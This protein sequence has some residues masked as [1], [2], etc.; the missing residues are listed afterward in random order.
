M[1]RLKKEMNLKIV[2]YILLF[3]SRSKHY[4]EQKLCQNYLVS[5]EVVF[6]VY[7]IFLFQAEAI[8]YSIL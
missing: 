3:D 1:N 6:Y 5:F 4:R 7:L 8:L 2:I